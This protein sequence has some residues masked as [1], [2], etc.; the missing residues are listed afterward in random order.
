MNNCFT[1][2]FFK[3]HPLSTYVSDSLLHIEHTNVKRKK[4]TA[5]SFQGI[6]SLV[7]RDLGEEGNNCTLTKEYKYSNKESWRSYLSNQA[8][9]LKEGSLL[10]EAVLCMPSAGNR[11]HKGLKAGKNSICSETEISGPG[12]S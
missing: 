3:N 10:C 4:N 12:T 7:G 11:I 5:I 1:S 9:K 2:I 8:L 6:C